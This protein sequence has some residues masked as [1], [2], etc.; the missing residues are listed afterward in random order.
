MAEADLRSEFP[1]LF[2]PARWGPVEATFVLS[3]ALPSLALIG[4]VNLVPFV[5]N[6]VAV[7]RLADGRPELPGGT[8]EPGEEYLDALRRE[9]LEEAGARLGS[10]AVL[11]AWAC[12]SAAPEPYRPH[13]PHPEFFRLVGYGD[14][15]LVGQPTNPQ[16]GEYVVAV[17]VFPVMEAAALFRHW[18]RPDLAALYVLAGRH[19]H[20]EGT[21]RHALIRSALPDD[22]EA[23]RAL[24][25]QAYARWVVRL[26]RKPSPMRDD[27][28]QRI[29]DGEAWVL[30][31]HGELIG[32][33][34]LK[35]GPEALLIPNIAVA[36]AQQG[37]GHGRRLI[38]FAEAEARRR[39]YAELRLFVNVLM[40]ENI[41]LYQ[42]LGFVERMSIE[43]EGS[44]RVYLC[45]AKPV[46]RG[47][48]S[49]PF[50][51]RSK[52]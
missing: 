11:G 27:Y 42:H 21:T 47:S 37:N 10:F 31:E 2:V 20:G 43:G 19:R 4:N 13:L 24:V 6:D 9:L 50:K 7:L 36:P 34:V 25:C 18:Q 41:S 26:G 38:A 16:H 23:V 33:V 49:S 32:L 35:D 51:A 30:E 48:L 28:A 8:L 3:Q 22:A 12:R 39:G 15:A 29:A 52:D 46:S 17:D 5:G 45:L 14:V 40:A 44:D 1:E